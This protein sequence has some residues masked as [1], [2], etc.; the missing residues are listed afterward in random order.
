[1]PNILKEPKTVHC[2]ESGGLSQIRIL[3]H[4]KI[5]GIFRIWP[6]STRF[7]ASLNPLALNNQFTFAE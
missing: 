1:M 4:L 5:S 2:L 3:E 6:S 7:P